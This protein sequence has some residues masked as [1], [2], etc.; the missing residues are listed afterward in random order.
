MFGWFAHSGVTSTRKRRERM[1][2][3]VCHGC[4]RIVQPA[5][6]P[7]ASDC[8]VDRLLEIASSNVVAMM[9]VYFDESGTHGGSPVVCIAGYLFR[10]EQARRLNTEWAETLSR[11]GV[12]VYHATDCGNGHGQFA[13]LR[14]EERTELTKAVIGI[15][16][17]RMEVG[18]AITMTETDFH[19]APEGPVWVKGGP[20]VICAM[21]A[22]SG[23]TGWC[24]KYGV[25]DDISYFFEKGDRH[26]SI[27]N[28]AISELAASSMGRVG[29]RYQSHSFIPK[30][31]NGPLQAA[32]LFAYEWYRENGK[33]KQS[34]QYSP[35]AAINCEPVTASGLLLRSLLSKRLEGVHRQRSRFH[36]RTVR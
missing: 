4:I 30:A 1:T 34:C 8:F 6:H 20:Y 18:F 12:S 3:R 13:H 24:D 2:V 27:V 23:I 28:G 32:D 7:R 14:T 5:C 36:A 16:L 29:F 26:Q 15:I 22:L 11:F 25:D 17:R 19:K 21:Y 31:G 10:V 33:N 9:E 35:Y